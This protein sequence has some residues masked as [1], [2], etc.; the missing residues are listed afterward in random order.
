MPLKI[1]VI[2]DDGFHDENIKFASN[3]IYSLAENFLDEAKK[4]ILL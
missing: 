3:F 1:H 4:S 2:Y